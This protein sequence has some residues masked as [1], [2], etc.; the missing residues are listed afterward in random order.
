M[1]VLTLKNLSFQYPEA[2]DAAVKDV[3][4]S[5]SKGEFIVLCGATG[6]GKSTLMRLLKRELIPLGQMRGEIAFD[7]IAQKD[8]SDR[9]AAEQIAYVMQH[10][11]QQIVT[12]KVWH[13][14]AFGLENL[15]YSRQAISSRVAEMDPDA[16]LIVVFGGT[17]D[18]GHGDAPFGDFSDRT[19]DTFC[20]A[21]HEL[22]VSLLEKYPT[23]TIMV[24]TPLHRS[25]G[26]LAFNLWN[27][28]LAVWVVGC[29]FRGI[30]NISGRH[31]SLDRPY[32]IAGWVFLGLALIAEAVHIINLRRNR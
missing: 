30:V 5:V 23:A 7:G 9:D 19:A 20:G 26:R 25:I 18:F 4:F 8:L 2:A 1:E 28:G 12:D 17:N 21:I 3:S 11:E 13:E 27:S 6:S 24:I 32:W 31:T 14:L 10:P 22:Y 16:D 29:L 15:G